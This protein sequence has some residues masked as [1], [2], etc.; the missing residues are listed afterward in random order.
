M[1]SPICLLF[2]DRQFT[3][4]GGFKSPSIVK[5]RLWRRVRRKRKRPQ[6]QLLQKVLGTRKLTTH[7]NENQSP[8]SWVFKENLF[9]ALQLRLQVVEGESEALGR[10]SGKPVTCSPSSHSSLLGRGILLNPSHGLETEVL[11]E[12]TRNQGFLSLLSMVAP[13]H[14]EQCHMLRGCSRHM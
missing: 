1:P 4:P 9:Q 10:V 6:E 2:Q 7:K 5:Q 13:Q 11:R 8:H 3:Q 12:A 14:S